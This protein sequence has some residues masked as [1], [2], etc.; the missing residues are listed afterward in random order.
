[1]LVPSNSRR[2]VHRAFILKKKV[3]FSRRTSLITVGRILENRSPLFWIHGTSQ[4]HIT[5]KVILNRLHA[6]NPMRIRRLIFLWAIMTDKKAICSHR[7]SMPNLVTEMENKLWTRRC[8][9][10]Q[11]PIKISAL[12][13]FLLWRTN[14]IS[15]L[16]ANLSLQNLGI[17]S[18]K[19]IW[20]LI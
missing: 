1:M 3:S 6:E 15:L 4:S 7:L 12:I 10:I 11:T 18:I 19:E 16:K 2:T 5:L 14:R 17:L 8:L 9:N 13:Q 20:M